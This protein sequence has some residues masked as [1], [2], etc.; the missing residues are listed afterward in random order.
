MSYTEQ[1]QIGTIKTSS[2]TIVV[3]GA[4]MQRGIKTGEW[5]FPTIVPDDPGKVVAGHSRA[6]AASQL[7]SENNSLTFLITG[8]MQTE[9][10]GETASRA[11]Q[12]TKCIVGKYAV[13]KD[14]VVSIGGAGGNTQGNA[15]D[16]VEYLEQHPGM[17][18][19]GAKIGILTNRFHMERALALFAQNPYFQEHGIELVPI[20]VEDILRRRSVHYEK[21]EERLNETE[22][23][24]TRLA[25]E[26]QGLKALTAGTYKS[27]A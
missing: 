27:V 23:M 6:I 16:L 15:G 12:L 1:S 26:R 24:K 14:A 25:L 3:L 22:E 8:G 5:L 17:A 7:F 10:N 4:R 11:R 21:W 2:D 18:H 9:A 19:H 20:I 13:P